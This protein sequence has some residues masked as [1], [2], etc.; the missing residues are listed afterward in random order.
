M[1]RLRV[2]VGLAAAGAVGATVML[3][4]APAALGSTTITPSVESVRQVTYGGSTQHLYLLPQVA[5][6]PKNPNT[7]VLVDGDYREGG[8]SLFASTNG[9][10]TW[11]TN[12][13]SIL[14]SGYQSCIARPDTEPELAPRFSPDGSTLYVA[15]AAQTPAGAQHGPISLA[16]ARST[17]LGLNT[18]SKIVFQSAMLTGTTKGGATAS[19]PEEFRSATMAVDPSDPSRIYVGAERDPDSVPA[20]INV[21]DQPAVAVSTDGGLNWGSE[22]DLG[23]ATMSQS[24]G[25]YNGY[26][27][28][29]LAANNGTVYA[30]AE[31]LSTGSSSSGSSLYPMYL[32]SS[33]DHGAHWTA[34]TITTGQAGADEPSAAIDPATGAIYVAWDSA[35]PQMTENI[36]VTHSLD[37][38]KTWSK[39]ASPVPSSV[40]MVSDRY[41]PGISVAPDGRVDVSWLDFRNDPFH[42]TGGMVQYSD[43]YYAYS[44]DQ[45]A[46]WSSNVR[47]TPTSVDQNLT[48]SYFAFNIESAA[49]ASTNNSVYIAWTQPQPAEPGSQSEDDFFTRVDLSGNVTLAS[50]KK[51]SNHDVAWGIGGLAIGLAVAGLVLLVLGRRGRGAPTAPPATT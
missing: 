39:P 48:E 11:T 30:V 4:A 17:D 42:P 35:T 16:V 13:T 47:V 14:P 6:D 26:T 45:G 18:T 23:T 20:S 7:V 34:S 2:V 38:G 43:T 44:T 41:T 22:T 27:P 1:R 37:G 9:G 3:G 46:T 19:E 36:F 24:G 31:G 8:C 40:S 12:S 5:V 49:I 10:L 50:A 28:V 51:S 25:P 21:M 33:T 15:M 29:L 32:Y